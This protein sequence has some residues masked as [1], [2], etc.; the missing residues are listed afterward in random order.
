MHAAYRTEDLE[1]WT[2]EIA[3]ARS[4]DASGREYTKILKMNISPELR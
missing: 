1:P 3:E 2:V 4:A